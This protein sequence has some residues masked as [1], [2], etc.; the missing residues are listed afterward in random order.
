[1]SLLDDDREPSD[2]VGWTPFQIAPKP[3]DASVYWIDL[4]QLHFAEPFFGETVEKRLQEPGREVATTPIGTL[5]EVAAIAPHLPM[6]AFVFHASRTGSTLLA[7]AFKAL[8]GNLVLGEPFPVIQMLTFLH[9]YEETSPWSSWMRGLMACLSQPRRES[10]ARVIVKFT[11]HHTLDLTLIR[12]LYPQ[13]P[14]VFLY[15]DPLEVMVSALANPP[16]WLKLYDQPARAARLFG[17]DPYTLGSL[18]R[19]DYC[20]YALRRIFDA[21]LAEEDLPFIDY[22]D[23]SPESVLQLAG[24]LGLPLEDESEAKLREVFSLDAKSAEPR[25]FEDDSARKQAEATPA[26]RSGYEKYLAPIA[27]SLAARR[28]SLT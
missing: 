14:R 15:R 21:A 1:M 28:L 18:T 13:T 17:K 3:G 5:S 6:G 11:S 16:H 10:E 12:R 20:A 9:R 26:M 4:K 7:N 25:P 22:R 23:L 19:E 8:P 24:R 27:E 2:L